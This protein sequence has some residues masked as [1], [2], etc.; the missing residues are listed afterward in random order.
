ML[1]IINLQIGDGS[2]AGVHL[3]ALG[4]HL[5]GE[6]FGPIAFDI[7]HLRKQRA[8]GGIAGAGFGGFQEIL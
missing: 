5:L 4:D 1:E 8:N 6:V 7:F 3:M 2:I